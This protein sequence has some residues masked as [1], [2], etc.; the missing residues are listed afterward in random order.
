MEDEGH[1]RIEYMETPV[2]IRQ[3]KK[4]TRGLEAEKII[5]REPKKEAPDEE[6]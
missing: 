3:K 6:I 5:S 1:R 4:M 2:M